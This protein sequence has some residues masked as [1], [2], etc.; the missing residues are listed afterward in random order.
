M[1]EELQRLEKIARIGDSFENFKASEVYQL[2]DQ[3]IFQVLDRGAFE[4]FKK[5]DPKDEIAIIETQ[6]MSQIIDK[7][8][9]E[10]NK[11]IEEGRLAKHQIMMSNPNEEDSDV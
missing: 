9:N 3:Y 7:I 11:K 6:K 5:I 2:I 4:A 1:L 8:K 10:I